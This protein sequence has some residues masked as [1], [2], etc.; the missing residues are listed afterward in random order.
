MTASPTIP[1]P[2]A[3]AVWLFAIAALIF[4]MVVIG[5]ITRLTE[6]GLSIVDWRPVTGILPPLSEAA[7]QEELAKYRSS[8]QYQLVN[9]GMSLAEFK[10]IFWWEWIHRF[11]GRMI[12]LAFAL[13]FAWFLWRRA[14]PRA[15]VPH[16]WVAL[17][18]GALQGLVGWLMVASGLVDRPSVS[19]Y[20]L[21]AHLGL[22]LAIYAYLLWIALELW[23]GGAP[24]APGTPGRLAGPALFLLLAITMLSGGFVAGLDA[25]T[26]YNTFPTMEGDW[27]P[28]VWGQMSPWWI[29][30]FENAA[31]AQFDHRVLALATVLATIAAAMALRRA[32]VP[33][34]TLVIV[35]AAAAVGQAGLGV[36][37]LLLHVPVGLGALHQAGAVVLLTVLVA[38]AHAARRRPV[39]AAA[40]AIP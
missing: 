5:G 9:R 24:T 7:W 22:A 14:V 32:A 8:P 26:I 17:G 6:S 16:L 19:Q 29:N 10:A 30:P 18:L 3:V 25:G 34:R 12:G 27:V 33:V 38:L 4:A 36:A 28:P 23:R 40:I 11:W 1:R 31:A 15:I 20:R 13:P 37:T 35:A 39:A 2:I 21:V